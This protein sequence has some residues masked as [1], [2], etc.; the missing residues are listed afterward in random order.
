MAKASRISGRIAAS[1]NGED[2]KME[3]NRTDKLDFD[4]RPQISRIFVEGFY[5]WLKYFSKDKEKLTRAL[6]HM[7][8]VSKFYVAV[9]GERVAAITAFTDGVNP[10][11]HLEKKELRR[12]L[13]LIG[14]A[15]AY[16]MLK[17]NLENHSYPF[18]VTARMGSIEFVA[19]A[20]EYRGRGVAA[21]L[22]MHIMDETPRA[23]YVLEVADT[24]TTAVRL[25]ERLGFVEFMR[26]KAP[27]SKISG[28]N[29]YVYMRRTRV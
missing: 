17:Q 10:P 4:Y 3:Y 13:G 14:G 6:I 21:D 11:I 1:K 18:D 20:P 26:T 15:F 8:D 29:Y 24:N 19:T 23:E 7:F 27:G 9:D 16:S 5:Q 22:I 2:S 12:H 28:V 25:Y